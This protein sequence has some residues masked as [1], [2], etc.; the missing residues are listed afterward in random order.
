MG[1]VLAA[2]AF[3][4]LLLVL[5]RR[6]IALVIYMK[7]GARS[8][9]PGKGGPVRNPLFLLILTMGRLLGLRGF[10]RTTCRVSVS[11]RV[12]VLVMRIR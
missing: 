6:C 7:A 9:L 8:L 2:V 12:I 4:K 1:R 10:T 5:S 11:L 3:S